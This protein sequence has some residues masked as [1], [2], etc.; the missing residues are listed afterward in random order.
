MPLAFQ[1]VALAGNFGDEEAVLALAD[2][3]LVAIFSRL[4]PA[5]DAEAGRWF[6]E[7]GFGPLAER[8]Q[9]TFADL[10]SVEAW[11]AGLAQLPEP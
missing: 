1:P 7:M 3:R 11:I 5:H 8:D 10:D 2:G 9:Q 4:G 6:L